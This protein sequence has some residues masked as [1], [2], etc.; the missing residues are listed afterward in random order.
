MAEE[1]LRYMCDGNWPPYKRGENPE[2]D[3][4]LDELEA[5]MDEEVR[6]VVEVMS[7][8]KDNAAE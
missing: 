3:K 6:K 1:K 7:D 8:K 5:D 4:I 2:F